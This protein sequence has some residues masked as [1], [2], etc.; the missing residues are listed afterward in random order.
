MHEKD[1]KKLIEN[2]F[3][4]NK[5]LHEEFLDLKWTKCNADIKEKEDL[6]SFQSAITTLN[7]NNGEC[8]DLFD[9]LII[10]N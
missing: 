4:I 6:K 7:S 10:P 5:V 3:T 2:I 9:I 1:V 8:A